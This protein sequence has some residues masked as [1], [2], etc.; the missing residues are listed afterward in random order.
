MRI[1]LRDTEWGPEELDVPEGSPLPNV[2][3]RVG[4]EYNSGG[5][6]YV[7]VRRAFTLFKRYPGALSTTTPDSVA[8]TLYL[9]AIDE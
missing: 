1:T 9:K 5:S 4:L 3:E 8:V 6:E 7:V 2:G